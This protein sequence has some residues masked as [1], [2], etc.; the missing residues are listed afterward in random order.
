MRWN[1]PKVL[2]T[3]ADKVWAWAKSGR[4]PITSPDFIREMDINGDNAYRGHC[5]EAGFRRWKPKSYYM[6]VFPWMRP[7]YDF[8]TIRYPEFHGG[9]WRTD[10]KGRGIKGAPRSIYWHNVNVADAER[11]RGC[12]YCFAFVETRPD[13][14]T[15]VWFPGWMA[16]DEYIE[17]A[18]FLDKGDIQPDNPNNFKIIVP[19]YS[20][21]IG[22]LNAY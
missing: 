4:D 9:N 10:V 18:L 1:Y 5:C 7:S 11:S 22:D 20:M 19:R 2:L 8:L 12:I 14:P 16:V 17:R 15:Y 13:E 21:Q 6:G 3:D